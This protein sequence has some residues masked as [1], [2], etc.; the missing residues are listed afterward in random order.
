MADSAIVTA[1]RTALRI[2][3]NNDGIT[4]EIEASAAACKRELEEVG[5]INTSDSDALIV[6]AYILYAKADFDYAGKGEQFRASF[7]SLKGAL[8]MAEDYN[9]AAAG[10]EGDV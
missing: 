3:G 7:V 5:I 8:A 2:S 10:E 9:T 4:A 1:I 6:R